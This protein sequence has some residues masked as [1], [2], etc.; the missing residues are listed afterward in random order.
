MR[1]F[2]DSGPH[3]AA[4]DLGRAAYRNGSPHDHFQ[5][6]TDSRDAVLAAFTGWMDDRPGRQDPFTW[7]ELR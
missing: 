2:A 6:T 7:T 1:G 3:V 5:T 4:G